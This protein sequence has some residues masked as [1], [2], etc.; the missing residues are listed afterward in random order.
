MPACDRIL[1][2]EGRHDGAGG[3]HVELQ[4]AARHVVDALGVIAGEFVEDVALVGQVDWNFQVT[5]CARLTCGMAIAPAPARPATLRKLRRLARVFVAS[6][7]MV[8][9]PEKW[10]R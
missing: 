8:P 10:R 4:A 2:L 3:Q 5:V 1:Q 9:S 6:D 7:V